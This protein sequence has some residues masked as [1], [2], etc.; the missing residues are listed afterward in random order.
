MVKRRHLRFA[1]LVPL[2][3]IAV[4]LWLLTG[5]LFIPTPNVV[6]R[7]GSKQDFRALIGEVGSG[8]PIVAGRI[9]REEVEALLG[10]PPFASANR[11]RVMYV[12]HE[13]NGIWIFPLCFTATNNTDNAI[14]LLLN[15]DDRQVLQR[16][17][18]L[19][20]G[21]AGFSFSDARPYGPLAAF[22]IERR[23]TEGLKKQARNA[24]TQLADEWQ[25]QSTKK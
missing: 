8:R 14:G 10:P 19:D 12:I 6:Y 3:L 25:L 11:R 22:T 13:K 2:A 21:T 5:C 23:G 9:S 16:W 1:V 18:E 15:F 17:T 7:T 20:D 4:S 24:S